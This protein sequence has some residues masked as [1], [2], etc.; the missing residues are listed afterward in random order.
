[1]KRPHEHDPKTL[2]GLAHA[3]ARHFHVGL[4]DLTDVQVPEGGH[5]AEMLSFTA[6]W[7]TE[8]RSHQNELIARFQ[9]VGNNIL[10]E[11]DLRTEWCVLR[12]FARHAVPVPEVLVTDD[13]DALGRPFYI[14]NRIDGRIPRDEPSYHHAGFMQDLD[15]AQRAQLWRDGIECLARIHSVDRSGFTFFGV[16]NDGSSGLRHYLDWVTRWYRW[17]C[18]TQTHPVA[19]AALEYLLTQRPNYSTDSVLWGDARIGNLIFSTDNEVIGVLD[20]EMT[21][22]GPGEVDLAWWLLIDHLLADGL[23]V[24]R[25]PGLP[26]RNETI[27]HYEQLLGRKVH[28]MRYYEILATMRFVII[29]LRFANV[30]RGTPLLET[31]TTLGTNS[32]AM[33]HLARLLELPVP[34]LSPD[35]LRLLRPELTASHHGDERGM[36]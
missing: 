1:M 28:D 13:G 19:D 33:Q 5:S 23:G 26:S 8:D 18:G 24:T 3:L 6:S 2:D 10:F 29:L 35:I 15:L 14:M 17:T 4:V 16:P 7:A 34:E 31:D 36:D 11:P 30:Y 9:P 12:E 25:L 32:H 20:W 27:S 22:I 21:A